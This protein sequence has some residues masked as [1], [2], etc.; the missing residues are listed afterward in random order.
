[1]RRTFTV[2]LNM[3]VV[4]VPKQVLV[5]G[6]LYALYS[7]ERALSTHLIGANM[8]MVAKRITPVSAMNATQSIQQINSHFRYP[9]HII[10]YCNSPGSDY[11]QGGWIGNQIYWTLN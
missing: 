3:Q 2:P 8:D 6:Q 4:P 1:M 7:V 10:T 5:T 9:T 11:R